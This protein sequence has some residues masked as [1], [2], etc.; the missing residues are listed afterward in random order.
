MAVGDS[1]GRFAVD[2]TVDDIERAFIE[3][4][5]AIGG[6]V[7]RQGDVG[8]GQ[9]AA[10]VDAAAFGRNIVGKSAVLHRQRADIVKR[11]ERHRG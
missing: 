10:V 9:H 6:R 5:L 1:R 3:V 4:A 2:N 7:V 8:Q 11:T